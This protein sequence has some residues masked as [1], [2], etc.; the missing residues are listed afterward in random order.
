[1]IYFEAVSISIND[2]RASKELENNVFFICVDW[3]CKVDTGPPYLAI[4]R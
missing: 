2:L 1:M 3:F 4:I